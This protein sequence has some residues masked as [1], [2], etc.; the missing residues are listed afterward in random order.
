MFCVLVCQWVQFTI[1]DLSVYFINANNDCGNTCVKM[2][3]AIL[4]C[5]Q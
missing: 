1:S 4:D 5:S 2:G 3:L